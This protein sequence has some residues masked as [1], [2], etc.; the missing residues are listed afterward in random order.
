LPGELRAILHQIANS[1]GLAGKRGV[2]TGQI[3]RQLG[4]YIPAPGGFAEE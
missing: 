1:N 2:I 3:M 4:Q